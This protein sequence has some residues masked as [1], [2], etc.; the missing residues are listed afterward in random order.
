LCP[1]RKCRAAARLWTGRPPADHA[2]NR[3]HSFDDLLDAKVREFNPRFAEAEGA[4]LG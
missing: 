2:K 3:S 4:L 1:A